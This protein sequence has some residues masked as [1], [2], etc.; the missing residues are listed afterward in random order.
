[1]TYFLSDPRTRY[2]VAEPRADNAKMIAYMMNA[3]F[4][5]AKEFDFPHKRAALMALSRE[6]YFSQ[7]CF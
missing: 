4:Y 2:V 6:A 7:F 3:G 1:M 5:R